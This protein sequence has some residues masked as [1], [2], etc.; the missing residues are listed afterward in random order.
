MHALLLLG[1]LLDGSFLEWD[2]ELPLRWSVGVGARHGAGPPSAVARGAEGGLRLSGDAATREWRLLSQR[3]PLEAGATHA[4]AYEARARGLALE[5]GR[6]D[7]AY[8]GVRLADGSMLAQRV[9]SERWEPGELIFREGGGGAAEV[10][11]FLSKTGALEARA[12]ALRRVE[13]GE[14]FDLLARQMDRY[15][16]H[17]ACRGVDWAAA[18]AR[19]AGAAREAAA[20]PEAFVAAVLPLLAE[21]GDLH[22]TV[23]VPPGPRRPTFLDGNRSARSQPRGLL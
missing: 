8:L 1:L 5:D 2:G 16:S 18:A 9:L 17:F 23:R 10:L 3:V 7:K 20:D 6:F 22:V 21:L 4:L 13:P 11:V 19:R 14:S 12:L 15:Y